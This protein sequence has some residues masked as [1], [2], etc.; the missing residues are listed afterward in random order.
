MTEYVQNATAL[1]RPEL[2]DSKGVRLKEEPLST[3]SLS[4]SIVAVMILLALQ[5]LSLT[6]VQAGDDTHPISNGF[7]NASGGLPVGTSQHAIWFGD[8]D[9][10]TFLDI[11]T[12]GY[13]G[14]RVW[15]GDGA[16]NWAAAMNGLPTTTHSGG[17]C[18]G[19]VNNDGNLDIAAA[20]YDHGFGG[21]NVWLGNG[22][23]VWTDASNG[24]PT[25]RGHTGIYLADINHDNNLDIA[26]ASDQFEG[27]PG[28][29]EV[30]TGDGAGTWTPA[31]TNLPVSGKYFAVWMG[32]VNEDGDTDLVGVGPGV[33]VWLGNGAGI[34]TEASNG[35][36]WTD[37]WMGVTL[38]DINLDGHL[39]MA[40]TM[41]PSHGLRAWLGDGT[42]NWTAASTGL[43]TTGLHYAIVLA[44]LVGDKYPDIL[45]A[46]YTGTTE[47]EVWEGIDGASWT[48]YSGTLPTGKII[49]VAAGD[50]NN[51]G[52]MDIG[53]AGE[54]FGV[55]VWKNDA[56]A[57]PLK[58][59]V[60]VPN[61]G[62]AWVAGSQ[63]QITWTASGGTPPLTIRIE[64]AINGLFG[65]FTIVSDGE[66]DD[67]MYLWDIPTTPSTDCFVRVNVTDSALLK[68]W[69]KS[70][71]S[72][73]VL[74]AETIPPTISNLQPL[75]QTITGNAVPTISADYS[76][77]SGIDTN[78]VVLEVDSIDV[79]AFATVT[80]TDVT[81]A[82]GETIAD[83]I[84]DVYLEVSDGSV[85]QNKAKIAWWF[86]V[87]T[88]SPVISNE[89]PTNQSTTGD[90]TPL[91]GA[92]YADASG[93]DTGSVLLT[94]DSVDV[95]ASAT[96]TTSDVTYIPSIPLTDGMHNVLLEASDNSTPANTGLMSW[97]FTVDTTIMDVT[98]PIIS[99]IAPANQSVIET[100]FPTI[101][102]DY[103]DTSGI[104]LS[105]VVLIVDSVDVTS[106]A[107]V[108]PLDISY[109]PSVQLTEGIH[110]VYLS[111]QDDS[112]N[113]NVA[114]I[115]WW[116]E[117]NTQAPI[118]TNIQPANLSFTNDNT[119]TIGASYSD[120]SGIDTSNVELR[121][122]FS[123]VTFLATVTSSDITF[124]PSMALSEGLHNIYLE[125]GDI[126]GDP[127]T[128]VVIWS[129]MVD[130][131]PPTIDNLTP[132]DGSIL[133]D[134]NPVIGAGF[135]DISGIDISTLVF[136]LVNSDSGGLVTGMIAVVAGDTAAIFTP[137]IMLPDGNY[138]AHIEVS[139]WSFIHVIDDWCFS[140]DTTPP[141]IANQN[142]LNESI[143]STSTPAISA[144]FHDATGINVSSVL[145]KLD[146]I[147]VTG[148]STITE[149]GISFTLASGL[150]DGLHTVYL[151]VEDISAAPNAADAIWYFTIITS[152]V[153]TD[154]DG[155][156][157]DWEIDHFGDLSQNP[158]NDTDGDGLTN[159]QEYNL[160][161]DP[162][163]T[164][165][166]G[167]GLL[168]GED[169]NPLV[170]KDSQTEEIDPLFYVIL[171]IIAIV[172][173]LVLLWFFMLRRKREEIPEEL[174]EEESGSDE[175]EETG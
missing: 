152:T 80:A 90:S 126:S 93:V 11:A 101:S 123:D 86:R 13:S 88:Q 147:D 112:P 12:A 109:T 146:S 6:V 133:N 127:K 53:A 57:P 5:G 22:A 137:D 63:Q 66:I 115:A 30:Y 35:L 153:D 107:T 18:L 62:E 70:N 7:V 49:G 47:V 174:D 110:N 156:P 148:S 29:I 120:D 140:I 36:P 40:V 164:D 37:V 56:I 99:N 138:C 8:I 25:L 134:K 106:S 143:V 83:G 114:T 77:A 14:V 139:D 113:N 119:P 118:I 144:T 130:T 52:Y 20:N 38:G 78:S 100:G 79:T 46:G 84:H 16:G 89:D 131:T 95:T 44:D 61:G 157:D 67:G 173:V 65:E 142:P 24:L 169:P 60:N 55:Q 161:T 39:D 129:F 108:N 19:D 97:W 2:G 166:D 158:S 165:T 17:I 3:K 117:V 33:H 141:V 15:T 32:D 159:I 96:V 48:K 125:V 103:D 111:L 121:L 50:I 145:L 124:T 9:N 31:S 72:F 105:S 155:L 71:Y 168:D 150:S 43:S 73:T 10:D 132:P 75:N 135:Y 42:S 27:N 122:D 59:D 68:N 149:N 116:F 76:D 172:I 34:W 85:N 175:N 51:D 171:A 94:V 162:S 26:V 154:N 81:Y 28:G 136:E 160:E 91:I 69:D 21:V 54:G 58:V 87:D 82:P 170:P 41:G 128:S 151:Y 167:D 98:P 163:N 64:Y 23:G 102:A 45:A 4:L 104:D 74:P 92:I 1:C